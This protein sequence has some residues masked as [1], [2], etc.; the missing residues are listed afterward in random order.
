MLTSSIKRIL[1][2]RPVAISNYSRI[3]RCV[4]FLTFILPASKNDSV[5]KLFDSAI[6]D[7]FLS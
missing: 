2:S 1:L 3:L 7:T 6:E 4:Q 5:I